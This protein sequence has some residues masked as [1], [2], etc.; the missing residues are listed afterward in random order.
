M[1]DRDAELHDAELK[2]RLQRAVRSV[3]TPPFLGA[4]IHA[5]LQTA[6]KPSKA[7]SWLLAGALASSLSLG[8]VGILAYEHGHLRMTGASQDSYISSVGQTI[9][10]VMR[11]GLG[12]HIHCS[13]FRKYPNAPKSLKE[14]AADLGPSF[15]P[16]LPI[17]REHV[18]ER[19]QL[20]M[21]HRCGYK[22]R[23]FVHFTFKN[24]DALLSIVIA[25]KR[26]GETLSTAD[27]G[28][29]LNESGV[30]I[31]TSHV[32]RFEI[33]SFDAGDYLAY[34]ISDLSGAENRE[35]AVAVSPGVKSILAQ[36]QG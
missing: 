32:Q 28:S 21:A 36:Q 23:R 25:R 31:Y 24:S 34:V 26:D 35:I 20:V 19:Y 33:A 13:V 12:D 22:Q 30:P 8:A 16:L 15:S 4:R 1:D 2:Q 27:L 14:M 17:V 10:P 7:P 9:A 3:E 29:A 18:P 5:Q 11:V 6:A